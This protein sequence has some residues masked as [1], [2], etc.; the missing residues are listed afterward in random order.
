MLAPMLDVLEISK[1]VPLEMAAVVD[2]VVADTAELNV[3]KLVMVNAPI[4]VP[5]IIPV[6]VVPLA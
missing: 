5:P 1:V 6:N 3:A 2:N 4:R